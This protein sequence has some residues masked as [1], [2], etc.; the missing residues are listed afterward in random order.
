MGI[1][2]NGS[3]KFFQI[4]SRNYNRRGRSFIDEKAIELKR[5]PPANKY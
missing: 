2:F 1:D 3:E 4:P 5:R